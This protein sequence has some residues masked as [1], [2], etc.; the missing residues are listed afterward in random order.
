MLGYTTFYSQLKRF[1]RL[2]NNINDFLYHTKLS[3]SKF[4]KRGYMH[5]PLFE[6]FKR[7][8]L[9]YNTDGKLCSVKITSITSSFT[10]MWIIKP[11]FPTNMFDD[12]TN[13]GI[14]SM[15]I[16][17]IEKSSSYSWKNMVKC[18]TIPCENISRSEFLGDSV[19]ND[20]TYVSTDC[21]ISCQLLPLLL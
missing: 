1:F 10:D 15:D 9:T 7:F 20:H 2:C 12:I 21:Q 6:Y 17:D 3:Y 14:N 11:L 13:T 4:V 8:R 16:D 19:L 5:S 18:S